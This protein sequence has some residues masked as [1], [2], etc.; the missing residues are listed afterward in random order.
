MNSLNT[1]IQE[2]QELHHQ[3]AL[4]AS[5]V[6]GHLETYGSH[7]EDVY[8]IAIYGQLTK[9]TTAAGRILDGLISLNKPG[10]AQAING[11]T[12]GVQQ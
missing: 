11:N 12:A 10:D 8:T 5:A 6:V 2:T 9:N 1:L 4:M 3:L 7:T